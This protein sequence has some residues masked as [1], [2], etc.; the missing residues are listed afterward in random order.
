M[1]GRH[2]LDGWKDPLPGGSSRPDAIVLNLQE[3]APISYAFLGGNFVKP[4]FD[5][6]RKAVKISTTNIPNSTTD[7]E[8]SYVNVFARHCG[9][10]GLMIFAREDVADDLQSV[11][12]ADV[13]VGFSEMANKGAVGARVGWQRSGSDDATY[14][15]FVSAHLAPFES[16]VQRRDQDYRDIVK[17]LQFTEEDARE[18][19]KDSRENENV[20]LLTGEGTSVGDGSGSPGMYTDDSYLFFCGDLN[21][22][23]AISTPGRDDLKLF[24]KRVDDVKSQEHYLQLLDKDQLTQ[25]LQEGKT[26]HGLAEQ[27]ID[28]PPTYKY[29]IESDRPVLLDEDVGNWNWAVHRWPSWCDRILF[30]SN[31]KLKVLPGKYSALPIFRTSDHR[32]VALS[33]AVPFESVHESG[34]AKLAPTSV[35]PHAKSRRA[36]AKQKELVVGLGAYLSLTWEGR[37]LIVGTIVFVL[38]AIALYKS[39]A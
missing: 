32:P 12:V 39:M 17:G 20:P 15:T 30:S 28:F 36:A 6:L 3:I 25:Q 16:E 19:R 23:T 9:L 8:H 38:G 24:P 21:Y 10:T 4:Y 33:V 13:G 1:F 11:N 5:H 29:N 2:L 14:T 34:F 35:D 18:W 37:S 27:R 7:N 26:L 22:R 31:E